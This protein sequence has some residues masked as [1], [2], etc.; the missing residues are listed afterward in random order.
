MIKSK[1]SDLIRSSLSPCDIFVGKLVISGKPQI[2]F[3]VASW[4]KSLVPYIICFDWNNYGTSG[5]IEKSL[6]FDITN[7]ILEAPI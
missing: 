5:K 2:S 3:L 7:R 1:T 6:C 4:M